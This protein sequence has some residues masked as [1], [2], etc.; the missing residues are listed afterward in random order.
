MRVYSK[1]IKSGFGLDAVMLDSVMG[2]LCKA[3]GSE[4]LIMSRE[5]MGRDGIEETVSYIILI[6]G[7]FGNVM[8][9]GIRIP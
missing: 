8:V 2:L 1:M 9:C 4:W 7:L 5:S 6:K 3:G